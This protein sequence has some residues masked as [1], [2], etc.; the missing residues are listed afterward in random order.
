MRRAK[1]ILGV[2]LAV[3]LLAPAAAAQPCFGSGNKNDASGKPCA[4]RV[5]EADDSP[6]TVSLGLLDDILET[7]GGAI[8]A[9]VNIIRG[10][11]GVAGSYGVNTAGTVRTVPASV[12]ATCA[13]YDPDQVEANADIAA[14]GSRPEL[15]CQV[16]GTTQ[17]LVREAAATGGA[18]GMR[19]NGGYVANDG[20]GSAFR[21]R[22]TASVYF[23]DVAGLG[24]ADLVCCPEVY[25]AP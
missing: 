21:I 23:Y 20:T 8:S 7:I 13:A 9:R 1:L 2:V 15:V 16:Q 3:L 17:V 18:L 12:T 19:Y 6:L 10:V 22:S 24:L 11:N 5:I 14:D 4:T 25:A